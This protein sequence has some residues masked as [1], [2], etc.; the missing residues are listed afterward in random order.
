MTSNNFRTSPEWIIFTTNE[1]AELLKVTPPTIRRLEAE[2]QLV[3]LP[4]LRTLRFN[5][6][7]VDRYLDR[8]KRDGDPSGERPTKRWPVRKGKR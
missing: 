3:A 7:S 1:V 5:A 4:G 2:G 8:N 6:K